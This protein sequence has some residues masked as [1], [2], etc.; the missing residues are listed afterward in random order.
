M[1]TLMEPSNKVIDS[2][3]DAYTHGSN[4]VVGVNKISEWP[5]PSGVFYVDDGDEWVIWKYGSRNTTD[6]QL[7]SLS[8]AQENNES[9]G[10]SGHTFPSGSII[11]NARSVDYLLQLIRIFNGTDTWPADQDAGGHS[12]DDVYSLNTKNFSGIEIMPHQP[13]MQAYK[14]NFSWSAISWEDKGS[15]IIDESGV[16]GQSS[17]PTCIHAG[18][19]FQSAIDDWYIYW[20]THDYNNIHLSTAPSPWGPWTYYGDVFSD[21]EGNQTASPSVLV[22]PDNNRLNLYY[23]VNPSGVDRRG[24]LT[25]LATTADLTGNGTSFSI[26][27]DALISDQNGN[28][29]DDEISYMKVYRLGPSFIGVYQGRDQYQSAP[30]IGVAFSDDGENWWAEKEPAFDNAQWQNYDPQEYT[31]GTPCL[32]Y[33]ANTLWLCWNDKTTNN[34]YAY[35]FEYRHHPVES[36]Y[37]IYGASDISWGSGYVSVQDFV[38][39]GEYLYLIYGH[40]GVIGITRT[41]LGGI[42]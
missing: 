26:V 11:I 9:S 3:S 2:L 16:T 19:V 29:D 33:L 20:S 13:K 36:P 15:A 32:A 5:D 34:A 35:P 23:H 28:W 42:L 37:K 12:L 38:S 8:A 39:D 18:S 4:S 25:K 22:D 14:T 31:G 21:T 30:G 27:G 7:E 1:A 17:Y 41:E 40:G 24:Q 10:A 6:G